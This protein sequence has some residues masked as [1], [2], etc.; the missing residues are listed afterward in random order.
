MK[1]FFHGLYY[2][3][4]LGGPRGVFCDIQ[5]RHTNGDIGFM[6]ID[7]VNAVLFSAVLGMTACSSPA[8]STAKSEA[9]TAA[10]KE[11]AGPP[12]PVSGK[13][14]FYEMYKP[15][16]AWATDLVPIGL[17]SEDVEGV[18]SEGGL[19]PRWTA[20]FVSSSRHEVRTYYYS[21]VDKPPLILKGVKADNALPWSGPTADAM[22]FQLSDFS[23]DSDAA[24]KTAA[25]KAD[26]WLKKHPGKPVAMSLGNATRFSA[27]M[28]YLLWGDKKDGFA[29]YVNATLGTYGAK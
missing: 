19:A 10:A 8:P 11:P 16:R 3:L 5:S 13:T 28:W 26:A 9:E 29:G 2:N 24:Y 18:P 14:A 12:Q 7:L 22:P 17:K 1:G 27:P 20:A 21:V 23:I 6:K 4:A 25:E 15:A